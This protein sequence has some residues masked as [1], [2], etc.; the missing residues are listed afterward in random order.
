MESWR[1][2]GERWLLLAP[3]LLILSAVTVSPLLQTVWLSFTDK[4]ITSRRQA[5]NWI[6]F[7][8]YFYT[9]TDPDFHD[10]LWRTL[11]FTIASVSLE[12]VIAVAVALLLNIEF[13]GRNILRTLI[14]LPWAI[15]TIVNAIMWRLIFHP[16]YGSLNAALTQLGIIDAY[17][18]WLGDPNTAMTMI[19][20]ADVW[21]NYPL[22]AFVV[23]AALQTIPKELFD[24]AKVEGASAWQRFRRIILPGILGPLLVVVVLRTIE[25]FRVFDIVYVMTRGGPADA[26]KTASFFVYQEY[27]A[28]LRAGSG[29]TYAV[30]VALISAALIAIYFAVL[31]TLERRRHA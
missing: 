5:V 27:F 29:A 18:S 9:L 1:Q 8:N 16:E 4:Q 17:R 19:V 6:G 26:T 11:Y 3:A 24:A 23:L 13:R 28:Y 31:H 22:I 20:L 14:I 10:S 21:K 7:E 2:R 25:A 30:V 12:T 15:P